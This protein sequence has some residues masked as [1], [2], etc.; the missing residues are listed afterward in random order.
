[1]KTGFNLHGL[2]RLKRRQLKALEDE[3]Y[4]KNKIV[5]LLKLRAGQSSRIQRQNKGYALRNVNINKFGITEGSKSDLVTRM[6]EKGCTMKEI[7]NATGNMY[8]PLIKRLHKHGHTII[9]DGGYLKLI[10]KNEAS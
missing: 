4:V 5:G 3:L 1:M 7:V 2:I 8:Y 6:L 9:K 10:H